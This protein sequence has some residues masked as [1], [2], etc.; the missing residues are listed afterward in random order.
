MINM[1]VLQCPFLIVDFNAHDKLKEEVLKSIDN[2]PN[3]SMMDG[4]TCTV[5]KT[6]WKYDKYEDREYWKIIEKD[7]HELLLDSFEVV[8]LDYW[9]YGNCWFQQ[10]YKNDTHSWH[11]HPESVYNCIYYL[12]LPESGPKT[13]F[14]NPI[15]PKE[16]L[17]PNVK[18][19]QVLIFPA[20]LYHQSP[21]SETN[22][23][24]TVIAFNIV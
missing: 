22:E 17:T 12:E 15:N 3:D 18:E 11:R 21:P 9:K 6:D 24:K 19:G 2:M 5:T 10:Y 8:H 4:D 16:T 23:R 7:M 1:G 14:R 13:M 20:V